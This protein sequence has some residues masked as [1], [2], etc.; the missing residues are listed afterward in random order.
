[1]L[2][3]P[4]SRRATSTAERSFTSRK[5]AKPWGT[6]AKAP[7][8]V[9]TVRNNG[10]RFIAPVQVHARTLHPDGKK[11]S[12]AVEHTYSDRS[13]Y[14]LGSWVALGGVPMLLL[15][16][17]VYLWG[18][19]VTKVSSLTTAAALHLGTLNSPSITAVTPVLP[20]PVQKIVIRGHGFGTHAAFASLDSPYLAIRDKS[21]HWAAG[22]ITPENVDEVTLTVA[23]WTDSEIVVS[24]FSGAYGTHWWRL[25]AG[26]EIEIVV[27]NP[28]SGGGPASYKLQVSAGP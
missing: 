17:A 23:S 9:R 19:H 10:Y 12:V 7:I 24:E 5:S 25:N 13:S 6:T 27:W 4:G 18:A 3:G 22:R 21:A 15:V 28:Q 26:D 14:W 8:Y 11:E 20:E 16:L 1:M 2:S